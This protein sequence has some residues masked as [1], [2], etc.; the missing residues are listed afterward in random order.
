MGYPGY[1]VS[2]PLANESNLS[3]ST[4][5]YHFH[6]SAGAQIWSLAYSEH[7]SNGSWTFHLYF[8]IY[9]TGLSKP[10]QTQIMVIQTNDV[11]G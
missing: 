5:R 1:S 8:T 7:T 2:I 4:A 9:F 3:N 11:G 10:V 6:L